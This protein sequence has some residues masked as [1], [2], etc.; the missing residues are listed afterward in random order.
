MAFQYALITS[1]ILSAFLLGMGCGWIFGKSTSP[2][3]ALELSH[4]LLEQELFQNE[5]LKQKNLNE[6]AA[7]MHQ[8]ADMER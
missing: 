5:E 1:L 7:L 4:Q 6:Y 2:T 8:L 3:L